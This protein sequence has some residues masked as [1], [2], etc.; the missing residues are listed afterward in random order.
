M[1]AWLVPG[2]AFLV[3]YLGRILQMPDWA[4]YLS[5]YGVVPTVPAEELE[6]APLVGLTALA[7]A[8]VALGVAGF[9]RRNLG[10]A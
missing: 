9:R 2:Y 4:Q 10:T 3:G 8:L 5:P 1:L 6:W 7:V